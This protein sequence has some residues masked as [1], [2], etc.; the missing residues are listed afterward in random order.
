MEIVLE[1]LTKR[2]DGVTALPP[3]CARVPIGETTCV[4]GPSGC[5][6]TTL[7]RLLMGLE[8]PSGGR[9]YGMPKSVSAV[10]QEDRLLPKFSAVTNIR[11]V[12]GNRV[13]EEEIYKVLEE[14]GLCHWERTPAEALSGG[15]GRRAAIARALLYPAEAVLMDEP[16]KGLDEKT[17]E[18]VMDCVKRRTKEKTLLLI[19]HE[20]GEA[21]FFGGH[22]LRMERACPPEEK[23]N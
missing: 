3:I 7:F 23:Q 21:A 14:L 8:M 19:T 11:L 12:T 1:K 18:K 9:I 5:G 6:K 13:S 2:Y 17:K 22:V 16:F 15:M 10:F 4:L 20:E